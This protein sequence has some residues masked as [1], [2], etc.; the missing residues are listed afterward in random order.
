MQILKK[1][2]AFAVIFTLCTA[3]IPVVSFAEEALPEKWEK[4]ENVIITDKSNTELNYLYNFALKVSYDKGDDLINFLSLSENQIKSKYGLSS[5][6]VKASVQIDWAI[7]DETNWVYN[8]FAQQWD[9]FT[10]TNSPI[11]DYSGS[12]DD[13]LSLTT[14]KTQSADILNLYNNSKSEWL[15]TGL[16]DRV[17]A[18][19]YTMQDAYWVD[20]SLIDIKNHTIYVRVRYVVSIND[21]E[22]FIYSDWSDVAAIGQKAPNVTVD[23]G[24]NEPAPEINAEWSGVSDWALGTVRMATEQGLYPKVLNKENLTRSINRREFAAI[25]VAILNRMGIETETPA[26]NPFVDTRDINVLKAYEAGIIAGKSATEFAPMSLISREEA[27][28]ILERVY[29]KALSMGKIKQL[30]A[31]STNVFLDDADISIWARDA[32]YFMSANRIME[33]IGGNIFAPKNVTYDQEREGYANTS[34]EQALALAVRLY[35]LKV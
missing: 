2:T 9:T 11:W 34:I 21:G 3:V 1:L 20:V 7:D 12:S 24:S 5:G 6:D 15:N 13:A 19:T 18:Y 16:K 10:S 35:A 28:V 23:S 31:T 17:G 4:P 27:A 29:K 32:V 14:E 30:N 33:G 8:E 22:K 25:A 26:D